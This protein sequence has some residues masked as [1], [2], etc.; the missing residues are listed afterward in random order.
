MTI[1]IKYTKKTSPTSKLIR[2]TLNETIPTKRLRLD[3][4]T[5]T[6]KKNDL[7][8]NWGSSAP[9]ASNTQALVLNK[10]QAVSLAANK[11][12]TFNKLED[13]GVPT[14]PYVV[15]S[16]EQLLDER[17]SLIASHMETSFEKGYDTFMFRTTV[18]GMGG[19]GI[20]V[21][22]NFLERITDFYDDDWDITLYYDDI[23]PY[24]Q[25]LATEHPEYRQ[26][27]LDTK[28]ITS[29]FA[30]RDEFRIHVMM[31]EIIFSQRKALRTDEQRPLNP[32]FMI[33]NHANGFIFQSS[34]INVPES[35]KTASINAVKALGLD[36]GA[37]DIRYNPTTE[38]CA[39]L[40]VN[41]APAI[42]GKTFDAY[43]S[44]FKSIYDVLKNIDYTETTPDDWIPYTDTIIPSHLT[45]V[46]V[47]IRRADGWVST[48]SLPAETWNWGIRH[49]PA[50]IVAYKIDTSV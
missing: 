8:I 31:N 12:H 39:V 33:R 37:V 23:Y 7:L 6:G 19:E 49:N 48:Y 1:R 40:E 13:A 22:G 42:T 32:S 44:S 2:D 11:I 17:I 10:P 29:Y 30:A 45:G 3:N 20:H 16:S 50:A 46:S 24:L 21:E 36:F 14:V 4:S 47:F 43:T 38:K 35:V 15:L 27:F 26:L 34:N 18:T 5:W 28:L 41:T 9:I 25:S